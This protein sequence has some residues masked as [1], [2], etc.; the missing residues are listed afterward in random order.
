MG[1]VLQVGSGAIDAQIIFQFLE[2]VAQGWGD[3]YSL[4]HGKGQAIGFAIAMVGVLPDDDYP[5]F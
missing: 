2:Y 5:H 4:I 1:P 3:F